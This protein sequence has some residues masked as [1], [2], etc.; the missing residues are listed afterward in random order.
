[1][2]DG[3]ASNDAISDAPDD[4]PASVTRDG[5]PPYDAMSDWIVDSAR[6]TSLTAWLPLTPSDG[7][8]KLPRTPR[9]YWSVTTR[10]L[11]C[12]AASVEPS[13]P[14]AVDDPTM[15][16]PPCCSVSEFR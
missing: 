16:L 7:A 15:L 3:V 5:S 11:F 2:A 8:K 1:M 14:G 13:R 9:R 12:P 4:C 10:M 6:M